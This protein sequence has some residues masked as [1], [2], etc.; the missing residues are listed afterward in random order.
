MFTFKVFSDEQRSQSSQVQW[1]RT[2]GNPGVYGHTS[3]CSLRPSFKNKICTFC[4]DLNYKNEEWLEC[5]L[6]NEWF[7]GK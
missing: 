1:Y 6:C 2:G 7:Q 4:E 5:N 3:V